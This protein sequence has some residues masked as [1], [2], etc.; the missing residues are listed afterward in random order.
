MCCFSKCQG[1]L[2]MESG[3]ISDAQMSASLEYDADHAAIRGRLH[4]RKYPGSW[5]ALTNDVNQCMAAD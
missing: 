5:S 3:A 2:G 4:V 1:A